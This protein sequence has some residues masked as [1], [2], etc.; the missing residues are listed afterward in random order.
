MRHFFL[1]A[2]CVVVPLL[3][4][5]ADDGLQLTLRVNTESA[6]AALAVY[7]GKVGSARD[8]ARLPG[9][10][11]ALA[12][13]RLLQ[14]R[15]AGTADLERAFDD[16]RHGTAPE[17]D[18]F[19]TGAAIAVADE[20]RE[21]LEEL[22]RRNFARRV[23]GTVEQLFPQGRTVTAVVPVY[24]T[25][26]GHGSIDAFANRVRWVGEDPVFVGDDEE[27]EQV[28]VMNLASAVRYGRTLDERFIGTLSTV[29]H[30]VFHA[31]FAEL[32]SSSPA[33]QE[34]LARR[35]TYADALLQLTQNEG[36]AHYLSF[37]QRGGRTPVDW[38]RRVRDAFQRFNDAVA[39]LAMPGVP[40][41]EA[42]EILRSSNTSAFWESFGAVAGLVIAREID[43]QRGRAALAETLELGPD[44]F[45]DLYRE[46]S[47]RDGSLPALSPAV[48][49]FIRP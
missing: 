46:L 13:I 48:L 16:A 29:A 11:L 36:I 5:Q 44:R 32:Q 22:Q 2:C 33:W 7:E 8:A 6:A 24:F 43:R 23:T 47:E 18:P 27:G 21:L 28:I 37:E 1:T 4:V 20:V 10:R 19:G 39:R 35:R 26:F 45:F 31:A 30:E 12:A 3:Q 17:G 49:R 14:Q 41:A 9:S 25:A 42:G 15:T 38:D 40:P 34:L